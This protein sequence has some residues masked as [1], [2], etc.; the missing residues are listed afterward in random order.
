[1]PLMPLLR[2]R[3]AGQAASSNRSAVSC[4]QLPLV[5]PGDDLLDRLVRVLVL[6]DLPRLLGGR[7]VELRAVRASV[8]VADAAGVDADVARGDG[9][10]RLL[11]RAHDRLE[12]RIARLVD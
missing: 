1:M 9:L 5:E 4:E 7:G 3:H 10:E 11:L 12:R 6:D 2:M 8:V